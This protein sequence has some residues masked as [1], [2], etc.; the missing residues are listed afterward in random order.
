MANQPSS[1]NQH[2]PTID[3]QIIEKKTSKEQGVKPPPLPQT[4]NPFT[5]LGLSVAASFDAIRR[6]YKE[7]VK[8]YHPDILVGPD[9]SLE[10][11]KEANWDFARINAAYDILKRRENEV[12]YEY[13]MFVDGTRVSRTAYVDKEQRQYKRDANYIDYDRIRQMAEYRKTHPKKKMWYEE[14]HD[15]QPA[16]NGFEKDASYC[17]NEKWYKHLEIFEYE[18]DICCPPY[19]GFVSTQETMRKNGFGRGYQQGQEDEE[20]FWHNRQTF[21]RANNGNRW[22]DEDN[23]LYTRFDEE[24]GA[25]FTAYNNR[26]YRKVDDNEF[27]KRNGYDNYESAQYDPTD[28]WYKQVNDDPKFNGNFGF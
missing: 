16:N 8:V 22:W 15:Y 13:D 23:S 6:A 18:H 21:A 4:N 20:K 7:K 9:A 24:E 25:S 1:H 28:T 17:S 2:T 19:N 3:A 14:E 5:L 26:W 27:G 12:V 10:E 11:R